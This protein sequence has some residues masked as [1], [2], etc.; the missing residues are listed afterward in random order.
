M[1]HYKQQHLKILGTERMMRAK[2][3]TLPQTI[4]GGKVAATRCYFFYSS[5]CVKKNR[6]ANFN[7]FYE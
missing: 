1:F 5:L 3:K 7:F 4:G 6:N 2:T